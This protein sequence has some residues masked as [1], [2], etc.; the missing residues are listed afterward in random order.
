MEQHHLGSQGLVVSAMGLGCMGMSDF[1]GGRDD[2]ESIATIHRA[3]DLGITF[4]DTADAYGPFTNEQ[5]VGRAIADRRDRV[6]LATKFGNVRRPDG[7]WVGVSGRPEYV[8]ECCEASLKRLGVE[9]IDLYYQHR[10]DPDTPMEDTVG[11][12]AEL[13]EQGK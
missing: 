9:R 8:R 2:A 7:S 3:I 12:M 1:Y 5:L 6:V 11:A 13:V 4:L 10:V